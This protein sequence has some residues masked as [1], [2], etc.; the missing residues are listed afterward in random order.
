MQIKSTNHL[1]LRSINKYLDMCSIVLYMCM[2]RGMCIY[3]FINMWPYMCIEWSPFQIH[4]GLVPRP[5]WML[6]LWTVLNPV[7][8][9]GLYTYISFHSRKHFLAS[10]WPQYLPGDMCPHTVLC[11]TADLWARYTCLHPEYC[12]LFSL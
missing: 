5:Q 3:V 2:H 4:R 9:T 11:C 6:E 12:S 8:T 7:Y 10:L 1:T